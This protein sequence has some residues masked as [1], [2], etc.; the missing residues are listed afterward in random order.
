MS[1]GC[2]CAEA[3]D[4][5][6][7]A[8]LLL[9][10]HQCF[11]PV[12]AQ[13]SGLS[14]HIHA[15]Q[16]L[17]DVHQQSTS[18]LSTSAMNSNTN[19]HGAAHPFDVL[20]TSHATNS[21]EV[22]T[23]F[24]TVQQPSP[25]GL[26]GLPSTA[27]KSH[28]LVTVMVDLVTA[29]ASY[30]CLSHHSDVEQASTRPHVARCRLDFQAAHPADVLQAC[31]SPNT[32]KCPLGPGSFDAS[33]PWWLQ[34]EQ[35]A[36]A[37][38]A[39]AVIAS[40]IT[41]ASNQISC[42]RAA[43]VVGHGCQNSQASGSQTGRVMSAHTTSLLPWTLAW[44]LSHASCD[45]IISLLPTLL[46][47]IILVA[48]CS[49]ANGDGSHSCSDTPVLQTRMVAILLKWEGLWE[50]W[51]EA[52]P[53]YLATA[54][55]IAAL[56]ASF[57]DRDSCSLTEPRQLVSM[58]LLKHALHYA[59][60]SM[61]HK[62]CACIIFSWAAADRTKPVFQVRTGNVGTSTSG[63]I[64]VLPFGVLELTCHRISVQVIVHYPLRC[65]PVCYRMYYQLLW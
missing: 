7:A 17:L 35:Q 52:L 9:V 14:T 45:A 60:F 43:L 21:D 25:Q 16:N 53:E 12:A 55:G 10:C 34:Q 3:C 31:V 32:M 19:Q 54:C 11:C 33:V 1:G 4:A 13:P 64:R 62:F 2:V 65:M 38:S 37:D 6:A 56:A 23:H 27:E 57:S 42:A 59:S 5:S 49:E 63:W 24:Y 8:W 22:D 51:M 41:C 39:A 47:R 20:Q 18:G 61:Y 30:C 15:F 40:L 36:A 44:T 26:D 48:A 50:P 58:M 29:S 28:L 46:D